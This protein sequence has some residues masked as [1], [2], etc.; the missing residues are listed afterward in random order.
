[1][2]Y[3]GGQNTFTPGESPKKLSRDEAD[4]EIARLRDEVTNLRLQRDR[5]AVTA[6]VK[7][8]ETQ[9]VLFEDGIEKEINDVMALPADMRP[10]LLSRMEKQYKRKPGTGVNPAV[11]NSANVA[12]DGITLEQRDQVVKLARESGDSFEVAFKKSFGRFPW[13]PARI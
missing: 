10:I 8:L 2:G 3:P 9:G 6:K 13:E 4:A 1:M 11:L 12:P 5:D 7:E